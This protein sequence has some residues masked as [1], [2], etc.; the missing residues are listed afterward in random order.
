M[1]IVPINCR[2]DKH[3]HIIS[4]WMNPFYKYENS[5]I[6]YEQ[7]VRKSVLFNQLNEL[8]GKKIG[9]YCVNNKNIYCHGVILYKL[10]NE[11]SAL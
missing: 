1:E 6:L 7:Y 11:T 4:K 5:L 10:L 2:G 8:N 9:C 3:R